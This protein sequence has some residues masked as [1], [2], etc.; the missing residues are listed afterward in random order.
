[1]EQEKI[2]NLQLIVQ[3]LEE[4]LTLY[5]NGTTSSEFVEIIREKESENAILRTSL[6]ETNEKLRK[7][8]KSSAEVIARYEVQQKEK[9]QLSERL[10]ERTA[11]VEILREQLA[12]KKS[13][14][15]RQTNETR[16]LAARVYNLSEANNLLTN[17][18]SN[19]DST[20]DK[21]Q[22]RCASLVAE[23]SEKG[24]QLEIEK[25]ERAKQTKE[26]RVSLHAVRMHFVPSFPLI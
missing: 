17:E 15:A 13:D 16:D 21:L 24:R 19:R 22:L 2:F 3:K 26:I 12:A 6:D 14:I 1:M 10:A 8:A 11:E 18:V 4:E 20:I 9:D 7:L 25:T 5:R 23:K